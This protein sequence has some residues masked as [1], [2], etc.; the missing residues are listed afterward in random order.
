[1]QSALAGETVQ[2]EVADRV[3][4]GDAVYKVRPA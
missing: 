2:V 4:S 1:V 3:R